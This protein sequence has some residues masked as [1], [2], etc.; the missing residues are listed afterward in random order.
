MIERHHPWQSTG[1]SAQGGT[2]SKHQVTIFI[3]LPVLLREPEEPHSDWL[4]WHRATTVR[5]LC[6]RPCI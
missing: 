5:V 1:L 2:T 6:V 3:T 4:A